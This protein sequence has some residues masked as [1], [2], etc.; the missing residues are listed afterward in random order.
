MQNIPADL[1]RRIVEAA[2]L[3]VSE[4]LQRAWD[5]DHY[6][7]GAELSLDGV[8][9]TVGGTGRSGGA[10]MDGGA[11]SAPLLAGDPAGTHAE[12]EAR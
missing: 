12:S 3:A 11:S 4:H 6:L 2:R 8:E 7:G 1:G 10:A 9:S 5:M